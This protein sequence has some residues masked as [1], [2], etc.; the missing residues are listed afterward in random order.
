MAN[1]YFSF[2]FPENPFSIHHLRQ[3]DVRS[4]WRK[5]SKNFERYLFY[6]I[7]ISKKLSTNYK[8]ISKQ[9]FNETVSHVML[10]SNK[11]ATMTMIQRMM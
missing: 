6:V 3:R 8:F 2:N 4:G 5:T 11:N 7:W 10:A 9:L 1:D